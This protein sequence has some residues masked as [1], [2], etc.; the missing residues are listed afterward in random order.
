[1]SRSYRD[2]ERLE[3]RKADS[4]LGE[5]LNSF[6]HDDLAEKFAKS[7]STKT[8]YRFGNKRKSVAKEKIQA[9]RIQRKKDNDI[10]DY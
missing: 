8:I 10:N 2:K 1:M 3:S 6:H 4:E 9:R 7:K 5:V